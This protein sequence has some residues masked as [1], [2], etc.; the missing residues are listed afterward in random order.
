[1]TELLPFLK[2]LISVPGLSGYEAPIRDLI[3]AAWRP[4]ADEVST[5]RL[6]SLHALKRGTAPEPRRSSAPTWAIG[7]MVTGLVDGF[8]RA[9]EVG[10]LMC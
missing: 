8:P 7:L 9:T 10:G 3:D 5:S 4:L 2:S 6:G 1:M